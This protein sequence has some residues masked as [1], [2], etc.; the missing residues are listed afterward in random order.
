MIR[1]AFGR[2]R[3]RGAGANYAGGARYRYGRLGKLGRYRGFLWNVRAGWREIVGG[4]LNE[5]SG[6][7]ASHGRSGNCY[8]R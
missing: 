6:L 8:Q 3:S 2:A 4:E 5:I 1:E 7:C